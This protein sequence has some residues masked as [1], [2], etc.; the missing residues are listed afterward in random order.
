[1]YS[2]DNNHLTIQRLSTLRMYMQPRV[3]PTL[4][5]LSSIH[6]IIM[7]TRR[8]AKDLQRP[9]HKSIPPCRRPRPVSQLPIPSYAVGGLSH[10]V[11]HRI[12]RDTA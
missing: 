4:K 11:L 7:I 10:V 3:V 12:A 1:M 5:K 6:L 2:R 8:I 9:Q